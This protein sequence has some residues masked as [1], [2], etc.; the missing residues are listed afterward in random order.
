MCKQEKE[1]N[2]AYFQKVSI[3]AMQD[4]IS[5]SIRPSRTCLLVKFSYLSLPEI[6]LCQTLASN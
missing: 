1:K 6:L 2:H 4:C 5:V 3:I